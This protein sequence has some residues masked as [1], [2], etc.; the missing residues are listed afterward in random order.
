MK[1]TTTYTYVLKSTSTYKD[2]SF[3]NIL[4]INKC[5]YHHL[6]AACYNLSIS[7]YV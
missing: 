3:Y 2:T 6:V 1:T 5:M 7:N 4:L